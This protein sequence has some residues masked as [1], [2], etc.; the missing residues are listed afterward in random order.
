MLYEPGRVRLLVDG[1][2]AAEQSIE[3][4][5]QA[6]IPGA[7]AIGQLV[8]GGLACHGD[9]AYVRLTRGIRDKPHRGTEPPRADEQTV[10]L[11]LVAE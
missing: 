11:W 4:G 5:G 10:G 2:V 3:R 8:E 9:I 6:P 1:E 7:L